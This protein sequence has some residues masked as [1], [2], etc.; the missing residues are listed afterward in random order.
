M[1]KALL[2]I[3]CLTLVASVAMAGGEQLQLLNAGK[4]MVPQRIGHLQADGTVSEW[5]DYGTRGDCR[6]T[7]VWDSFDPVD[8]TDDGAGE[9]IDGAPG[10][11]EGCGLTGPGYRWFFG[12]TYCVG[13]H[14]ADMEFDPGP[15]FCEQLELG[16]NWSPPVGENMLVIVEFFTDFDDT[17]TIGD[18]GLGD[19]LGG[20]ILD[21]GFA[22]PGDGY[23][24]TNVDL[25]G[26][27]WLPFD[28]D[29]AMGVNYWLATYDDSAPD[30]YLPA[31]CSQMM[32][33]GT[34]NPASD[35]PGS[36]VPEQWD[37]DFPLNWVH[38][39]P[40]ECYD[41][42]YGMCPDPLGSMACFYSGGGAGHECDVADLDGDGTVGH[43]DLGIFLANW[44]TSGP[45][46]FDGD[47]NVGHTDLGFFLSCW[48]HVV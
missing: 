1:R 38:E 42:G 12:D 20:V 41:Y 35:G 16:W 5:M 8:P 17:C 32:L 10:H 21:F 45:G 24:W 6:I 23:Y 37:D 25:C 48:G 27:D 31:T 39:V 18:D 43:G 26:L 29:G 40:D 34:N 22:D 28:P 9:P 4:A 14:T 7:L 30:D 13:Y 3:C 15:E 2:C 44:G 11:G 47:G 33:W 36:Q 19:F 46:D